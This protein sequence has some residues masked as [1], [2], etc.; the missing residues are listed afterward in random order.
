[1]LLPY[2]VYVL[3]SQRDLLLYH[4]YTTK[5]EKR[6]VDHNKGYT[7]STAKRRPLKLVYC[8]F[9]INKKDAQCR[10]RYFK[11]S[12]GKRMLKLLLRETYKEIKYPR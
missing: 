7:I 12:V 1:M 5:I 11:T 10:E 2:C 6:I 9:F 8:E 4:G 3:Q